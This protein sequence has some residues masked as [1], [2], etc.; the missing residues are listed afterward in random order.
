MNQTT[1]NHRTHRTHRTHRI[2]RD[3][4]FVALAVVTALS[5]YFGREITWLLAS[6]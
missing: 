1:F 3:S 4:V 5:G 6:A 2:V